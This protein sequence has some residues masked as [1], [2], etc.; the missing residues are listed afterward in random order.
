MG[1]MLDKVTVGQIILRVLLPAL[2]VPSQQR[3][4][5][6]YSVNMGKD[7][8]PIRGRISIAKISFFTRTKLR[9]EETVQNESE[10]DARV[11]LCKFN[12]LMY[13]NIT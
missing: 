5:Y 12:G 3:S 10:F 6:I 7:N 11:G 9:R 4:I 1:Y 13:D 2:S 8:G